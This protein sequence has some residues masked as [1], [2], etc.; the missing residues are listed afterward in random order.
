MVNNEGKERIMSHSSE[1]NDGI[2][3]KKY[4]NWTTASA[5]PFHSV[6]EEFL[7]HGD[8]VE[9]QAA[10][11]LEVSVSTVRRWARG[12]SVPMLNTQEAIVKKLCEITT[13]LK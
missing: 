6:V 10:N 7:R 8:L 4:R 13:Q 2:F 11:D 9:I 3:E 5:E 1:D 12:K